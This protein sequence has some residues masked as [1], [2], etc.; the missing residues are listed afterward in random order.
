MI[1]LVLLKKYNFSNNK[2]TRNEELIEELLEI[3]IYEIIIFKRET[4][5]N[6][7]L[8]SITAS[9]DINIRALST[10]FSGLIGLRP[11]S[12]AP[13]P[14]ILVLSESSSEQ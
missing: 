2:S 1:L 3:K 4:R 14:N 10:I 13:Y 7:Y 12:S 5:M 8:F 9:L 11:N 6:L